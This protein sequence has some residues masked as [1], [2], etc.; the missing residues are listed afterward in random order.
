MMKQMHSPWKLL[1][2]HMEVASLHPRLAKSTKANA[3]NSETGMHVVDY[4]D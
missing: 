1:E 2:S 3:M 4:M